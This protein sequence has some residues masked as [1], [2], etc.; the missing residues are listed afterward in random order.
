MSDP[1][2]QPNSRHCFVCGLENPVGLKLRFFQQGPDRVV[3]YYTIPPDYQGYPGRAHGGIVAAMLDEVL[4]RCVMGTDPQR[5]RLFYTAR[6]TLHYRHPVPV[7]EPL[8]LEGWAEKDRGRVLQARGAL[9][10]REGDQPLVEAEALLV[11]VLETEI[12]NMDTEAL[13]WRIYPL[14]P[15]AHPGGPA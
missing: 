7:G 5:S 1:V 3:A 13:G 11:A 10:L 2:L 15:E 12:Q 8:R 9:F 14:G 6:L 4:G